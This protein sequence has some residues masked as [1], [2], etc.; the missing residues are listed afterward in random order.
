MAQF[1]PKFFGDMGREGGKNLQK[2][3]DDGFW[4]DRLSAEVIYKNH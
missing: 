2:L 3:F 4:P 1:F